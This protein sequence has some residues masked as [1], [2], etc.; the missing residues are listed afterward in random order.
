MNRHPCTARRLEQLGTC[1]EQSAAYEMKALPSCCTRS[2]VRWNRAKRSGLSWGD[3]SIPCR[4]Y[5]MPRRR[6][7]AMGMKK[8]KRKIFLKTPSIGKVTV[9]SFLSSKSSYCLLVSFCALGCGQL[10]PKLTD[11]CRA[12]LNRRSLRSFPLW[13]GVQ[14]LQE[15]VSVRLSRFP[16]AMW[17]C[18]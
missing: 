4:I 2:I 14:F 18:G 10:P 15:G 5:I 12:H 7:D 13:R 17:Y 11:V 1:S 9:T 3:S 8:L 6:R 16:V